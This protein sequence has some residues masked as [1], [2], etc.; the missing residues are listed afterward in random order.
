MTSYQT[1]STPQDY[2]N[3]TFN[4]SSRGVTEVAG[5]MVGLSNTVTTILGQLAFKTSEYLTHTETAIMGM[6]TAAVAAFTSSTQ[7][8]IK[9]EQAVAN[10]QAIGGES[11]NAM[12]IGQAAMRYSSQFGMDV[13]SMTEGLEALARAGLTA[14]DVMS[15]VLAEGVKLSKLEGIDLEDSIND[16]IATTNL[17]AEDKYD[18]NSKE[19]ADAVKT[20]NQHI[21]STS[22]SSPINAQN[23]IQTLQHAGGYVSASK[24]DQDDLFA[25]IAQ[26]GA[27]GTKGEMAGTALRAFIAAG[28]KD[29]AQRALKRI[30]LDVKDLWDPTGN[31]MLPVSEMKQVLDDALEA[32]GYS[33]QEKLEFY[34]DFAGYKQANQIM[35]IDTSEVQEYKKT[36]EQAWDLGTKLDTILG[37][38]HNNIQT[39]F[40]T[41]KNFMTRTGSTILPLINAII[42]PIKWGIQLLDAM[43]FSENIVGMALAF[44]GLKAAVLFI[45]R[46]VPSIAGLYT[47]LS[48]SSDKAEGIY[49]HFKNFRKELEQSRDILEHISDKDY[50]ANIRVHQGLMGRQSHIQHKDITKTLYTD[51]FRKDNSDIL[52]WEELSSTQKEL[53]Y[54]I[55]ET[56]KNTNA[57]QN[58]IDQ[59][60][61]ANEGHVRRFIDT[62]KNNSENRPKSN[63][64]TNKEK[65]LSQE[66]EYTN[67]QADN[68]H[69][70]FV[71]ITG[72]VRE[73]QNHIYKNIGKENDTQYDIGMGIM[74]VADKLA[75]VFVSAFNNNKNKTTN[76]IDDIKITADKDNINEVVNEVRQLRLEA[77][78]KNL[79]DIGF[80]YN[81]DIDKIKK[82]RDNILKDISNVVS[83]FSNLDVNTMDSTQRSRISKQYS[84]NA[85]TPRGI[86]E[87]KLRNTAEVR[88]IFNGKIYIDPKDSNKGI[89]KEQLDAIEKVFNITNKLPPDDR[90]ARIQKIQDKYN[91]LTPNEQH[92]L[93]EKAIRDAQDE[94][95]DFIA[96]R[97]SPSAMNTSHLEAV[98][99][100]FEQF[101]I[102]TTT[103]TGEDIQDIYNNLSTQQQE[104]IKDLTFIEQKRNANGVFT[105]SEA[106]QLSMM[107]EKLAMVEE[108]YNKLLNIA[109][110]ELAELDDEL[111][112][113][114]SL[115]ELVFGNVQISSPGGYESDYSI[116]DIV[117]EIINN[118]ENYNSRKK[119]KIRDVR[120]DLSQGYYGGK[121]FNNYQIDNIMK[122]VIGRTEETHNTQQK[123]KINVCECFEDG[124]KKILQKMDELSSI[125]AIAIQTTLLDRLKNTLGD[126][127][128]YEELEK[129]KTT[130]QE[131]ID[132]TR[133]GQKNI[134]LNELQKTNEKIDKQ[135][136]KINRMD[137]NLE[138]IQANQGIIVK[139]IL[140]LIMQM[141]QNPSTLYSNFLLEDSNQKEYSSTLLIETAN[142]DTINVKGIN[143][144][145][146]S[147]YSDLSRQK[148]YEEWRKSQNID[149]QYDTTPLLTSLLLLPEDATSVTKSFILLGDAIEYF[150]RDITILLQRYRSDNFI[151]KVLPSGEGKSFE[152]PY[153]NWI[154]GSNIPITLMLSE[155]SSAFVRKLITD[156]T[157]INP[158]TQS[159]PFDNEIIVD[160][161]TI[162]IKTI[163]TTDI[164]GPHFDYLDMA[165]NESAQQQYSQSIGPRT[166]TQIAQAIYKN[167]FDV[168]EDDLI[169][170]GM[171]DRIAEWKQN[172]QIMANPVNKK[173]FNAI[174]KIATNEYEKYKTSQV[175]SL[176]KKE[177]EKIVMENPFNITEDDLKTLGMDDYIQ[178]LHQNRETI[179]K[180]NQRHFNEAYESTYENPLDNYIN[181]VEEINKTL[182]NKEFIDNFTKE[183]KELLGEL[184][185]IAN[186]FINNQENI[187]KKIIDAIQPFLN[188]ILSDNQKEMDEHTKTPPK[189]TTT[190]KN[191]RFRTDTNIGV[192]NLKHSYKN[193][194]DIGIMDA[195]G[196]ELNMD[197]LIEE[198]NERDAILQSLLEADKNAT[199]VGNQIKENI[200]KRNDFLKDRILASNENIKEMAQEM[201]ALD[202]AKD[203][204]SV[205]DYILD[206]LGWQSAKGI[207]AERKRKKEQKFVA[208]D[209]GI[210]NKITE[211]QIKN[212]KQNQEDFI[213]LGNFANQS[214]I[215]KRQEEKNKK[216]QEEIIAARQVDEERARETYIQEH[217]GPDVEALQRGQERV[218]AQIEKEYN[219]QRVQA[220][221][222]SLE[223]KQ[224]QLEQEGKFLQAQKDLLGVSQAVTQTVQQQKQEE[225]F[226]QSQK[227]LLNISKQITEQENV[228]SNFKKMNDNLEKEI[229]N[230]KESIEIAEQLG[231]GMLHTMKHQLNVDKYEEE[232]KQ[233]EIEEEAKRY[234]HVQ[235]VSTGYGSDAEKEEIY[236]QYSH[237][238]G[239]NTNA[240]YEG[241]SD[242]EKA[243]MKADHRYGKVSSNRQ[244]SWEERAERFGITMA[245]VKGQFFNAASSIANQ[246]PE[247]QAKQYSEAIG[248]IKNT[249]EGALEPMRSFRDG[250]A[251]A[252]EVF[253][254]LT[255]AVT[256]M[257]IAIQ[258]GEG[259]VWG[260]NMAEMVLNG[261]KLFDTLATWGLVT[262]EQA[263]T[264]SKA[265]ATIATWGLNVAI[266]AF[267][268]LISGPV[269]AAIAAI[270]AAIAI[271]FF[272][273][274]QH[275]DALKKSQEELKETTAK[276]GVALSQYKDLK[277]AREA[278]T[279]AIKKQQAARKEAIALYELEAARLKKRQAVHD[280]A[281][282]RND[283]VWGE[284]GLRATMQKMGL[285]FIAGG[286]FESQYEN[287]EGTTKNI[288]RVKEDTL[289]NFETTQ[290]QQYVAAFY[291]A[292]KMAFAEI[293]A[294]KEDL[295][296]LYDVES[297]LIEKYGSIEDARNSQEFADAVQEFCDATGIQAETA[298]KYLDW[299]ETE[300]KVNQASK[301][302]EASIAMVR[303]RADAKAAG[304]DMEYG[305]FDSENMDDVG[306][307]MVYAQVDQM[308]KDEKH[309]MW[310]T[311]LWEYLQAIISCLFLNFGEAGKHLQKAEAYQEGVAELEA[312]REQYYQDAMDYYENADRYDYGLGS[313][314]IHADTPFG[315][316]IS[317]AATQHVEREQQK[318]YEA[319]GQ[320]MSENDYVAAQ[321]QYQEDT[322]GITE[323]GVKQQKQKEIQEA[324]QK[325]K[326]KANKKA[327]TTLGQLQNNGEQAHRDALD[328]ID[329]IKGKGTA[330]IVS[331]L[332]A[333]VMSLFD[334]DN[335]L[336]KSLHKKGLRDTFDF[337]AGEEGTVT[338]KVVSK[339]K[340]IYNEAKTAYGENGLKGVYDYGKQGIK[341][342]GNQGIDFLETKGI[343]VRPYAEKGLDLFRQSRSGVKG[344]YQSAKAGY[345]EN[346]VRGALSNIR[347]TAKSAIYG[348]A[349]GM[350]IMDDGTRVPLGGGKEGLLAK[351]QKGIKNIANEGRGL[352][353]SAKTAYVEG[354]IGNVLSKGKD[355]FKSTSVG[356]KIADRIGLARE[357]NG[358]AADGVPVARSGIDKAVGVFDG[359][360]AAYAEDGIRGVAKFGKEA[361][362]SGIKSLASDTSGILSKGAEGLKNS[363]KP[364]AALGEAASVFNPKNLAS[365]VGDIANG[366]K[367]GG[368]LLKGIG[369]IG[370]PALMALGPA[371]AF[372]DKASELNPFDG[373]HYNE[374][375]SEKKALQATGEVVGTTA[376]AVGGVVGGLE[377]AAAGAAIGT[378]IL[379]GIGTAIGA[380]A[381][382]IAGGWL[383]DTIFQPIGEAIGGT[384]GWLGDNLLGGIQN[385][386]GTVWDGLTGAA[387]GVW[388][389]VSGA[390]S[391]VW[392]FLTGGGKGDQ[393]VGGLL[394]FTPIGIGIN[395]AAGIWDWLSGGNGEKDPYKNVQNQ[396]KEKTKEGQAAKSENTIIIKNININTEDDPEKI[397][398]ALMNLIIEM[399]EQIN[400]RQ[401][402][403]TV[404]EPPAQSTSNT[405]NTNNTTQ[406]QGTDQQSG[407]PNGNSSTSAGSNANTNPSR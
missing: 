336:F 241:L 182:Y 197:E 227:D 82:A 84:I 223:L 218:N 242:I 109:T 403:R 354:G 240:N 147:L 35:K 308:I 276:Q 224:Q 74:S 62:F 278:E 233:Q 328:I 213:N 295:G 358:L 156:S 267:E 346:G 368:T 374:D 299:L 169:A 60:N 32:R 334:E 183:N 50:L 93:S 92:I 222:D 199:E 185:K 319:T 393:P 326:E 195:E 148:L 1:I 406:A 402:S 245:G 283:A 397:K 275:A 378:A 174:E 321:T 90:I 19:Y 209:K 394:G 312:N 279:D 331:G 2:V 383:G 244:Q 122:D 300:N 78:S 118:D 301:V 47:S 81:Y 375:G 22:E 269:L 12:E 91:T 205:P 266:A 175:P 123:S 211:Q 214:N 194:G 135:N 39:L 192:Q 167:P 18:T 391:E 131:N 298:V 193:A 65:H 343:N 87:S 237:I 254:P 198:I 86:F 261:T 124:I 69:K 281:K 49:G 143:I 385:V 61:K 8:A 129:L 46:V 97:K 238:S 95:S 230:Q 5:E 337:M 348:E 260:L 249:I 251:R 151:N 324:Q 286:D 51:V 259:I 10:V 180:R 24:I 117:E 297:K 407:T 66:N 395:A 350:M 332:G 134:I 15:G 55:A 360:K 203:P 248:G 184:E 128:Y 63:L 85:M 373:P 405:Q 341:K 172:K 138:A 364:G 9:F 173:I 57:Y 191:N 4:I 309:E 100:I 352:Y 77:K 23:I 150:Y 190:F 116:N 256:A 36:I 170:A 206:L 121:E 388:D 372:A 376:G 291:D 226:L 365:G 158:I 146:K 355:A 363:Y 292:N 221:I 14:T 285:G 201:Y 369:R 247:E 212:E 382:G 133:S 257:D 108:A 101:N 21:V 359:A 139:G 235:G 335:P 392:D 384:I 349:P 98:K 231:P 99:N 387:S 362:K 386:A 217:V 255:V 342:L 325:Q 320:V 38:T 398:S 186:D 75:A 106:N 165:Q 110:P 290:E 404:G 168:T 6:G 76:T 246:Y 48:K 210:Q 67:L 28:Q 262:A 263:E 271:L 79:P 89:R 232:R 181:A 125:D 26:L 33:Q 338:E 176:T 239:V 34:S 270:V 120:N 280:E 274:R 80:A 179:N 202:Y 311:M 296:K 220:D 216:R 107:F 59:F 204:S 29:Q 42:I 304:V 115:S 377:G 234:Q 105:E 305:G 330:G 119:L 13:N 371:L 380:V 43:P 333:G 52:P 329:A 37:T 88:D 323:E 137:E 54:S 340:N 379:P 141:T 277:K 70:D 310:W 219:Q 196:N 288:R 345:A 58:I 225:E 64:E 30:G 104:Y 272:W 161:D 314:S 155:E 294:Y 166:K 152:L 228:T 273:E 200:Q 45:N 399:Q 160:A 318:Q 401:V 351:G 27:K 339:G 73:I 162:T 243:T 322:F 188:K 258:I 356:G 164:M 31:I 302:A 236:A 178:T 68:I 287:Y 72:Q 41:V 20:M 159:L 7:E 140:A 103:L 3:Y 154:L 253:P 111:K 126:T 94:Y 157:I 189:D 113:E 366:L 114:F 96:N 145:F 229:K 153:P 252:S 282:A 127:K 40:Q 389:A 306:R 56:L 207:E 83:S 317:S 353:Q 16:L 17:L 315:G 187:N 284:Y 327:D 144:D 370:G 396:G 265:A 25:V 177:A 142:I 344:L 71:T 149:I 390:A 136:E 102:D 347:N 53:Y 293:D 268:I 44:A 316:A 264:L 303:A 400:P 163:P 250:L 307:A 367:G 289:G 171:S 361:G 357:V 130:N 381:G 112:G 11:I 132:I 313:Y 215:Q 208:K